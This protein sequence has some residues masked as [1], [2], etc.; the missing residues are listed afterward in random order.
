[1]NWPAVGRSLRVHGGH[2]TPPRNAAQFNVHYQDL[3]GRLHRREIA[4]NWQDTIEHVS[5]TVLLGDPGGGKSTLSKKLCYEYAKQFQ[6]G[7]STLPIYIQLRTYIA[8]AAEDEQY[9]LIRYVL[10]NVDSASIDTETESLR[11]SVLYYLRIGSAFVV[12]DGLDEVLTPS[13]RARVVQEIRELSQ[14]FPLATLLVT[15]RYVGYETN[16]LEGF[17]HLGMDHLNRSAIETIYKNVTGAVLKRTKAQ[18]QATQSAFMS[19]AH[20]KAH[21]LI[22]NPLLLTLIV[23][24]YNQKSEIPDNRAS[25]YSFCADLLFERWDGYRDITPDLPE[26]YRLFD[27]FKHLSAILYEREEYGGTINKSDLLEEARD[28]FRRDYVDNR[29]GRSAKAAHHMVEH[30]TGRAWILHEVGEGVFEFTHRTFLEFFYAKH[31]ETVYEGTEE[32]IKECLEHV[33]EGSRTVPAHLA[34]QIRTKDKRAASSVVC[35]ALTRRLREES[36]SAELVDFCLDAL[37]YL[38][39]DGSRLSKFVAVL[40][41]RA[42]ASDDHSAQVKLLCTP[43]PL[44]DSILQSALPALRTVRS[45]DEVRK[46]APALYQMKR[47]GSDSVEIEGGVEEGLCE[48]VVSQTYSR[49]ARSPFLCK[50]AFDLDAAVNWEALQKFG[51]RIWAGERA[52][53]IQQLVRDSRLMVEEVARVLAGDNEGGRKYHELAKILY[54]DYNKRRKK[55]ELGL[56]L[57]QHARYAS[58]SRAADICVDA[59]DLPLSKNDLELFAFALILF[60]ELN[61]D[62]SG[63]QDLAR[64]RELVVGVGRAMQECGSSNTSWL[65]SWMA[66]DIRIVGDPRYIGRRS[67]MFQIGESETLF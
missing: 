56:S 22:R 51:F 58:G 63:V 10:E 19:D 44:R 14:S 15:S 16:P 50:L 54:A 3:R 52:H 53:S 23:I 35:D 32:L 4:S 41:P 46:L 28:F 61:G 59:A 45:V 33:V 25:L 30:L 29:E 49:Q 40:T 31:L 47:S 2:D 42:L 5:K 13:N 43:S 21:E 8:K 55:R 26:R 9:S 27:L 67:D 48:I 39:P 1:M 62:E 18:I 11:T 17:T 66:G 38:L 37:G 60:L 34:L 24:I 65:R 12:A 20:K 57:V 36:I 7:N 6:E 64:Y